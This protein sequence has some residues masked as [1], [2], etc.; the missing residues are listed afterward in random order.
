M[1]HYILQII[2]YQLLFL[3]VYDVFLKKETFFT[4]NRCYLL[5]TPILSFIL[6]FI[7]IDAIRETIPASYIITVPDVLLQTGI[8]DAALQGGV[9]DEIVLTGT[10]PVSVITWMTGI[11][12]VGM[13]VS[14]GY[15]IYKVIKIQ[16]LKS[17]GSLEEIGE[18]QIVT[19]P[20][21]D[22]A[23]SFFTTIFL[24]EN[25]SEVQRDNIM[26]HETIHIDERH[27]FDML[28]FEILRIVCWFNPLVYVYQ[29]KMML[30]QEY[31]AD[32]KAVSQKGKKT[33]YQSLLS[34][35]FKTENISFVNTF[36][37]HSL[38]KKRIIMLQKTKSNRVSQLKYLVLVPLIFGMLV[39]TSCSNDNSIETSPE[40]NIANLKYELSLGEDLE[41][42]KL[43]IH[44][45][46]EA[47]LKSHPDYVGWASKS[48]NGT[49]L[50][51]TVHRLS[52]G[53]PEGYHELTYNFGDGN[54]KMYMELGDAGDTRDDEIVSLT[55]TEI[56]SGNDGVSF[57]SIDQ[58][59]V[60][61]NC[62]GTNQ[63][64]KDCMSSKI[65]RYVNT[66]FDVSLG[67]KLNLTGVNKIFAIFKIDKSG[68]VVDI[69]VRAPHP[70]LE[71][72]TRRVIG[73]LPQME[74][75]KQNGEP[76]NVLY[77]LPITFKI[78]S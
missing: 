61:P 12:V 1:I 46:Y 42:E 17:K 51:Y 55:E 77:S 39:Y 10:K 7:K 40:E 9:L 43:K 65:S 78:Q 48:E 14:L 23:F 26:L 71:V 21:T 54:Y 59:P 35:V 31:T 25:L 66:E 34:Q 73:S 52:E 44:Q 67:K 72:E 56:I 60:F 41:G 16:R 70:D 47:F 6:P 19:L 38:I 64:R 62:S 63:E 8:T 2:A 75:G 45:Q 28:F 30:L 37:N 68:S 11:W 18:L 58:V 76:V 32:A 29:N 27:S 33:Y 53:K 74:P 22:T 69:R 13:S 4:W 49:K 3:V 15:F 57:E 50:M 5:I 36:F 24:G 20:N